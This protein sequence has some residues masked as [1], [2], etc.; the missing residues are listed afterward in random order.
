MNLS[1]SYQSCLDSCAGLKGSPEPGLTLGSQ[2]SNPWH[3]P[4]A[5]LCLVCS[6][7]FELSMLVSASGAQCCGFVYLKSTIHGIPAQSDPRGLFHCY[8]IWRQRSLWA[9]RAT[10]SHRTPLFLY[11]GSRSTKMLVPLV[12]HLILNTGPQSTLGLPLRLLS[13]SHL[14][15][16]PWGASISWQ[17]NPSTSPAYLLLFALTESWLS[18]KNMASPATVLNWGVF[19]LPSLIHFRVRR[20]GWFS[21][22]STMLLPDYYTENK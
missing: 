12:V 14:P 6:W 5:S 21:P 19:I 13:F 2:P 8:Q 18:Y 7:A 20:Q 11:Y 15:S 22:N 16:V 17:T 10:A 9:L 4:S 3:H 1:A